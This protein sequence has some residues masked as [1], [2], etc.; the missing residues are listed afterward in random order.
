LQRNI[1]VQFPVGFF[2]FSIEVNHGRK[3]GTHGKEA[4]ICGRDADASAPTPR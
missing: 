4:D 1:S 2:R 3:A